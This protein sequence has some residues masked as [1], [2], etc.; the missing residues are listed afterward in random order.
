MGISRSNWSN[1]KKK[2]LYLCGQFDLGVDCIRDIYIIYIYLWRVPDC[3]LPYYLY[4]LTLPR[5][6]D[7]LHMV[8]TCSHLYTSGTY[9]GT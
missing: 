5:E 6:L 9:L 7:A 4:Y 2:K 8:L 3:T 1:E